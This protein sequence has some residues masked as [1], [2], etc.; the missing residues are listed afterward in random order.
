[1]VYSLQVFQLKFSMRFYFLH[2]NLLNYFITVQFGK[3]KHYEAHYVGTSN[4]LHDMKAY[5]GEW[6]VESH[7]FLTSVITENAVSFKFRPFYPR[8]KLL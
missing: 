5:V 1:M 8:R 3:I 6:G 7:S 4:I 2:T